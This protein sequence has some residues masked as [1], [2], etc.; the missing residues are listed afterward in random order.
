MTIGTKKPQ[1]D[2][3]LDYI[4]SSNGLCFPLCTASFD[5]NA[6]VMQEHLV[7]V[8]NNH[9]VIFLASERILCN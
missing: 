2:A 5:A 4:S 9:V 8:Q 7:K 3:R 6:D 1:K